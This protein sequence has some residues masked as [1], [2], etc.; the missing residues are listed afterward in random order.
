MAAA[1]SN[2]NGTSLTRPLTA[3]QR[4][5][6]NDLERRIL[7]A[8]LIKRRKMIIIVIDGDI[9]HIDEAGPAGRIDLK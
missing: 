4:R 7:E 5:L 8:Q 9:C 3:G 2:L 6:L 1:K